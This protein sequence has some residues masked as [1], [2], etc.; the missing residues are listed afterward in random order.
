[1]AATRLKCKN[2]PVVNA[3]GNCA[4]CEVPLCGVCADFSSSDLRCNKCADANA[5]AVFV[6]KLSKKDDQMAKMLSAADAAISSAQRPASSYEQKKDKEEKRQNLFLM[7]TS[8]CFILIAGQ[9]YFFMG[10][11]SPLT[12]AEIQAEEMARAQLI[13]CEQVFW[14]IA[15][16]LQSNQEPDAS[17]RCTDSELPNVIIKTANDI[18]VKHPKPGLLGYS[19]IYVSKSNPIPVFVS[20]TL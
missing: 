12:V 2:H 9:F 13:N 11:S 15:A 19:E 14:E 16:Q 3:I 6:A 18:V 20:A 1:M 4:T 8:G 7:V 10:A 17:L 5:A